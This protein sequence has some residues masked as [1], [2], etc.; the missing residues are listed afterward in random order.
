MKPYQALIWNE[1]RQMRG[2]VIA[3]AGVTVLLWLVLLAAS[4]NKS[5]V[6]YIE[7]IATALAI[8]LPFLYSA[9]LAD[10][11]AKECSQK[12]D[13]FLL[14]MPV[15][16]AKIFFC[17]YLANL[18]AFLILA[19]LASQIMIRLTRLTSGK[20]FTDEFSTGDWIITLGI[21]ASSWILGHAM[22]FVTSLLCKKPGNSITGIIIMPLFYALMLPGTMAVTL[23]FIKDDNLW[24]ISSMFL[25]F[26]ILYCLC[27]GFGWYLWTRRIA[28]GKRILKPVIAVLAVILIAPW[29]LY[30]IAYLIVWTELKMELVAAKKNNLIL[31]IRQVL[32]LPVPDDQNAV[33]EIVKFA[34]NYSKQLESSKLDS[35]SGWSAY[36]NETEFRKKQNDKLPI[37]AT[38]E[39]AKYFLQNPEINKCYLT[40]ATALKKPFYQNGFKSEGDNDKYFSNAVA[41]RT[42]AVF[43]YNRAHALRLMQR[44]DEM[45][46]CLKKIDIIT[47]K[48]AKEPLENSY[49]FE[50]LL[51]RLKYEAAIAAGTDTLSSIKYYN[52][53]IKEI[54]SINF[55]HPDDTYIVLA[56]Q[57]C[58]IDL[59][60]DS[61]FPAKQFVKTCCSLYSPRQLYY[62]AVWVQWHVRHQNLL[63]L[64]QTGKTFL[65]IKK[66]FY[67]MLRKGYIPLINVNTYEKIRPYFEYKARFDTYKICL[68]L[69]IYKAQHG[70]FPDSLQQLVPEILPEIPCCPWD[71]KDYVYKPEENGFILKGNDEAEFFFGLDNIKYR[72]WDIKPEQAK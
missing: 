36:W 8:G 61:S 27:L 7:M 30:G 16:P 3:L 35:I 25:A 46:E 66:D 42:A 71:G 41:S 65:E 15:S 13:S 68:A 11:F 45:F 54:A 72:S 29:I 20:H 21:I 32:P 26:V 58:D 40:L 47:D 18:G 49:F 43:L 52:E 60:I 6:E 14:E 1:W 50:I 5:F 62:K 48:L 19:I 17:K 70:R 24:V 22:V 67:L 55:I 51:R 56:R 59:Y 69:K 33:P 10:S 23:Y 9:M 39:T 2:N 44:E 57:D 63:R 53:M 34:N 64:A 28:C 38:L 37:K 4:F 12:T 31:D